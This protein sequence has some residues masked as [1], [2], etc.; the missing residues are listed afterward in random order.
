MYFVLDQKRDVLYANI[1]KRVDI[2]MENGLLEEVRRLKEMGYDRSLVSMQG[3][4]YKEILAY[5]DGECSLEEAGYSIKRDTRH[6]AKRQMTW[7]RR[8]R[9]V[10]MVPKQDFDNNEDKILEYM[11]ELLKQKG[12]LS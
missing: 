1:D 3:I 2:M 8:E 11:L 5:L 6:F 7:F 12:I 9:D 4:G 10:T